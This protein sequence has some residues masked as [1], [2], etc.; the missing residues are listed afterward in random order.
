MTVDDIREWLAERDELRKTQEH[1]VTDDERIARAL[2]AE[3]ATVTRERADLESR[4]R[5]LRKA[6]SNA[7]HVLEDD[8]ADSE[9][10]EALR[11]VRG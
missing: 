5:V 1:R 7:A 4:V 10:I 8:W 6:I 2:L 11:R 3:L 9:L